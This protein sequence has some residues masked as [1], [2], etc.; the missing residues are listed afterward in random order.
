MHKSQQLILGETKGK[1]TAEKR[2]DGTKKE[3]EATERKRS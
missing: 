3:Q 2:K 1:N